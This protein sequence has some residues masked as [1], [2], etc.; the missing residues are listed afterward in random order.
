MSAGLLAPVP[1]LWLG[2]QTYAASPEGHFC[3]TVALY[4]AVDAT[5]AISALL[6]ADIDVTTC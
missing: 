3:A 4:A 5:P 2:G 6:D 1:R